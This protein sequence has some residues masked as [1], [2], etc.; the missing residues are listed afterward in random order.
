MLVLSRKLHETIV[1]NGNIKV[2]IV[3]IS[4]HDQRVK[5]G[6]DAPDDVKILRAELTDD[7]TREITGRPTKQ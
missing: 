3:G 1:I 5:L 6:V 2:T 4:R 7:N